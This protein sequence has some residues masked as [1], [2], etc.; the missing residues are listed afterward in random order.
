MIPGGVKSR[1]TIAT[2]LFVEDEEPLR[3]A[4]T[5]SLEKNGYS[6]IATGDGR[7]AV[8]L[9]HVRGAG[10]DIVLLDLT[11]PGLSGAEIFREVRKMKRDAK[12]ILTSAY[13]RETVRANPAFA[14]EA[15]FRFIRKPYR[16]S[17]LVRVLRE[18][19]SVD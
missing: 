7:E 3:L 12:I 14:N 8:E 16:I 9:F 15:V 19:L 2:V 13:D 6:V 4:A 11:L 1:P 17:E 18:V 10:I 5:M